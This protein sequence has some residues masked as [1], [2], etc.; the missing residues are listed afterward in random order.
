MKKKKNKG[1]KRSLEGICINSMINSQR[2][3]IKGKKGFLDLVFIMVFMIIIA[4]FFVV[5]YLIIRNLEPMGEILGTPE[6]SQALSMGVST[7]ANLDYGFIA[8]FIGLIIYTLISVFFI[9]SHP[10]FFWIGVIFLAILVFISGVISNVFE[11]FTTEPG[12]VN[13]TIGETFTITDYVMGHLP[14]F[15]ALGGALVMIVLLAK[16]WQKFGSGGTI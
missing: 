4:I 6:S 10:I 9:N 12:Q 7:M 1:K 5:T 3:K 11:K 8:V 2:K 13:Q 15:L 14:T 16:P